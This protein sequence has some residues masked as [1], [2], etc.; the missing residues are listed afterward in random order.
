MIAMLPAAT[1]HVDLAAGAQPDEDGTSSARPALQGSAP[2]S[3]TALGDTSELPS[4]NAGRDE[5]QDA[6]HLLA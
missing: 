5:T 6:A 4:G 3:T 2:S 1:T